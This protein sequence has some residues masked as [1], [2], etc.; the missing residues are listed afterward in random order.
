PIKANNGGHIWANRY[1]RDLTDIFAIQNEI[2]HAIVQQ[3]KVKLLPQ[4]KKSIAQ[5]PTDNVDAYTYYL[6]GRDF[7]Y[8]FSKRYFEL[9][10][11]MFVKAVGLDPGSPTA[12][13][14]STWL[15]TP[16]LHSRASVKPPPG[17]SHW[18]ISWPKP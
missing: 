13:R 8:R 1:D 9:A 14:A 4:E 10:R 6:R 16:L 2:T 3:L 12:I 7:L 5:L 17:F 18:F 11:R 15:I